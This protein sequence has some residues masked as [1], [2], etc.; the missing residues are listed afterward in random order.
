MRTI[1]LYG[2]PDTIERA[3]ELILTNTGMKEPN[4]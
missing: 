2:S 1:T 4:P 3:R